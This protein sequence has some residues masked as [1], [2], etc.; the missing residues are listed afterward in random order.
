MIMLRWICGKIKKDKIRNELF[1]EH[2][3]V[4]II[5]DKIRESRLKWF[6][7]V[8]RRLVRKSLAMKV[9]SPPRRMGRPK[10]TWMEVVKMDMRKCNLSE[11]LAQ[12]RSE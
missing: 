3:G 11:N 1:Q 9:V 6:G 10:R 12:D 4:A 8:Q 7:H 5:G 2:L